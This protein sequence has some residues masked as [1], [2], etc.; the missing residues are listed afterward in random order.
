MKYEEGTSILAAVGQTLRVRP[1]KDGSKSYLERLAEI[2][3]QAPG[4]YH[5]W[6][7]VSH[8]EILRRN[9]RTHSMHE[10][11]GT[12]TDGRCAYLEFDTPQNAQRALASF[13]NFFEGVSPK[14][15]PSSKIIHKPRYDGGV[16]RNLSPSRALK[17]SLGVTESLADVIKAY[18]NLKPTKISLC[19][20]RDW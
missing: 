4:L 12:I 10:I 8:V 17:A 14:K 11:L 18:R 9:L 16:K 5:V 13:D 1:A 15:C 7:G 20:Y 6:D 2:I 19:V 3:R